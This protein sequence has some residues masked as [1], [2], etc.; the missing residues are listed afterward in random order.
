MSLGFAVYPLG[1]SM[2]CGVEGVDESWLA[3]LV[4]ESRQR[5]GLDEMLRYCPENLRTLLSRASFLT[6]NTAR[7]LV[8]DFPWPTRL[9]TLLPGGLMPSRS[10]VRHWRFR[11]YDFWSAFQADFVSLQLGKRGFGY[12]YVGGDVPVFLV[13]LGLLLPL[14]GELSEYL[15][16]SGYRD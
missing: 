9:R 11:E 3:R 12:L 8:S 7:E 6:G 4:E 10:G 15:A 1:T 5:H 2:R 13:D 14:L 16:A